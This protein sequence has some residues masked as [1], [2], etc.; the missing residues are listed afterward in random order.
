MVL[1][2]LGT[3]LMA[4]ATSPASTSRPEPPTTRDF[5]RRTDRFLDRPSETSSPPHADRGSGGTGTGGGGGAGGKELFPD[6]RVVSLYGAPQ[7]TST[8]LGERTPRQ[9]A[10]KAKRQAKPYRRLGDR[11]VIEAFDLIA[12]VATSDKGRDGKYRT[13]QPDALIA[14]YLRRARRIDGRLILDIQPGRSTVMRELR[15]LREW[16]RQPEVDIAIDPEWNVGRRG[17]PGRTEGSIGAKELNRV[18]ARLAEIVADHDLPPKA[19][20]VHQFRKGSVRGGRKLKQR[21]GVATTLNFDGIG[22]AKAKRSGYK[23]LSRP[24]IF[25]GFSLFYD[26][27]RKPVMSPRKVLR[28]KPPADYVMYQ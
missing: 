24:G 3:A 6:N 1:I 18:S 4:P 25:N 28:L 20:I 5:E 11:P 9:A 26:L 17:V 2:A 10:R 15:A 27:D 21:P 8:A 13:R 7:L 22:S 23:A 12:V 14:Q 19:L 16:V